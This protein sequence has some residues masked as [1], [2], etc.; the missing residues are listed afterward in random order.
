MPAASVA[1]SRERAVRAASSPRGAEHTAATTV[2]PARPARRLWD[3]PLAV[4]AL[5][6]SAVLAAA[7][8]AAGPPALF[9][10]DEGLAI[11][12]AR[13]LAAGSGWSLPLPFA[14]LDPAGATFAFRMHSPSFAVYAKHPLYPLLLSFAQRAGGV[15]TMVALSAAGTVV[16][17]LLAARLSRHL[18]PRLE[19][20]V[21]WA[22]GLGGPLAFDG[23]IV[24]AHSIGAAFATLAVLGAV[25]CRGRPGERARWWWL[26][27]A[28]LAVLPAVMLRSEAVLLLGAWAMV[29][30]VWGVLRRDR[31][32]VIAALG[33]AVAVAAGRQLD[34]L[35][36]SAVGGGGVSLAD[37]AASGG[38][39]LVPGLRATPTTLFGSSLG[40]A[41][42]AGP[43]LMLASLLAVL[44]GAWLVR[45]RERASI[46]AVPWAVAVVCLA[47]ALLVDRSISVPGLFVVSPVLTAG[48]VL[49]PHHGWARHPRGVLA[50]GIVVF[51]AA[52]L[53][54]QYSIGGSL[55]WGGRYLAVGVP[56]ATVLAVWC[57]AVRLRGAEPAARRAAVA[58]LVAA[59][60]L[61]A[62]LAVSTLR[63]DHRVTDEANRLILTRAEATPPG[64][65]G[66]PVVMT[67]NA[68]LPR[69]AWS[70]DGK[71]RWM[72]VEPGDETRWASELQR[73]GI[74][75]FVLI[76]Q[77]GGGARLTVQH[78]GEPVPPPRPASS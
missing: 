67:T 59:S 51:T 68:S 36:A 39:G 3:L 73:V 40:G 16:A 2:E 43:T 29:L 24:F 76:R 15:W 63:R 71:V 66:L 34:H 54:T 31:R 22:V 53:G 12:Q 23:L 64:D 46:A 60:L 1:P 69:L 55:E 57:V 14:H 27:V 35:W 37:G 44:V 28:V 32:A 58:G 20:W 17:A 62:G 78:T 25:E 49:I 75:E 18:D 21:F 13:H 33:T 8:W 45:T 9:S 4:H 47:A 6:L 30:G 56:V 61:I 41:G 72:L 52:V 48:V 74:G 11:V 5:V 70:L 10:V 7:A 19:R 42:S 77:D 26:G 65:G 38:H 50:G